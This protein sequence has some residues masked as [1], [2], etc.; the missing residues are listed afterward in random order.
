[1][2]KILLLT[3]IMTIALGTNV[4]AAENATTNNAVPAKQISKPC[5]G[6]FHKPPM[7]K[8]RIDFDKKLKLTEEQKAKAKEIHQKGFEQIK[9]VMEKM[10]LKHEEIE[11]VKRSSA[12]PEVQAEQIVKL[13]KEM[14][15]LK[16]QA[17]EI[18]MKNMKEF[19][20][21]LTETQKKELKK[22]KEEGRKN[23]EKSHKKQMFKMPLK[24]GF[25]CPKRPPVEQPVRVD[26]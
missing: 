3:A 13:R 5:N 10:R 24:P 16:H 19:E 17:R 2:K 26:K 25:E 23:F 22:I 6:Q 15:E 1:M 18:Q 7:H 21:I 14:K 8:N 9:P 20:S 11:A 4:F 12:T